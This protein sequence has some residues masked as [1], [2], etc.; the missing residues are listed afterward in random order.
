[1]LSNALKY[2]YPEQ[3]QGRIIVRVGVGEELTLSV[4]DDGVGLPP[5][6]DVAE[7]PSLGLRLVHSL[8]GQLRGRIEVHR[9]DGTAFVVT[10]PMRPAS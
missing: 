5:E 8:V 7:S 6:L 2:A 1:L 4:A 10:L 3:A 9:D